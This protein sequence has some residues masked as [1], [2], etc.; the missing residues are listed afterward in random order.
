MNRPP[1]AY[2]GGQCRAVPSGESS[3]GML[4]SRG[5]EAFFMT[6]DSSP[7]PFVRYRYL[8]L[9]VLGALI[10]VS[11]LGLRDLWF[12]DEPDSA[13]VCKAMFV[14][15]DWIVPR[16]LGIIWVDYPPIFYWAGALSSHVFGGVS[17]FTLRL[18]SALAA[19]GIALL[20]CVTG[21]RWLNPRVGLWAGLILLT[22]MQFTLQAVGY[23]PDML[24]ALMITA[25]LLAYARCAGERP[26]LLWRAAG[27]ALFGLA[28]LTKGPLGLLLPGLTLVLWHGTRREWRRVIELAPLSIV[29]LAV[30]LP[31]FVACART[32]GSESIL[33][34][35]YAQNFERFFNGARGHGHPFYYYFAY[36]GVDLL[37]WSWLLPFALW[38]VYKS[39]LWRDRNIQLLLWWLGAFIAFLSLAATKRQLYLLP[40]YPAIALLM[41]PWIASVGLEDSKRSVP[42]GPRPVRVYAGVL[43]VV[44]V[45]LAVTLF[46]ATAS[47]EPIIER[48]GLDEAEA[49]VAHASR[50]PL[51]LFGVALLLAGFW[52][53]DAWRRADAR[54]VL[55][56]VV[57]SHVVIYCVLLAWVL[58]A[59]G[60]YHSFKPQ[61]AWIHEQIGSETRI[62]LADIQYAWRQ[63]GAFAYFSDAQVDRI[64]TTDELERFFREHPASVAL[65]H[66]GDAAK[67]LSDDES[68]WRRRVVRSLRMGSRVYLVVRAP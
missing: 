8:V 26:S 42:H 30:Y 47:A 52:I 33:H 56:R 32:M 40:A 49:E 18:P 46:V 66:D 51:V 41:A 54:A 44:F 36:I 6:D 62:G 1:I 10:Y 61:G 5:A 67:V 3:G 48:A 45:I 68:A 50:T 11:F 2:L 25:G 9:I 34:E 14:T 39:G 35:L 37:P 55:A 43:A 17:A 22:F 65:V 24:F 53:G 4:D 58:P 28:M 27:F 60:S 31:W 13:E 59:A 20:A 64:T 7:S 12:P 63:A 23:R 38:R 19:I 21:S 16:R 57:L 15:G 29:S